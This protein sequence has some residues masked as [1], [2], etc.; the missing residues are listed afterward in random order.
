[1]EDLIQKII[2]GDYTITDEDFIKYPSLGRNI[3]VMEAA[4]DE[5]PNF[6]KYSKI[7]YSNELG[8]MDMVDYDL[9]YIDE[10]NTINI[11][12]Y[13]LKNG[14]IPKG[15]DFEKNKTLAK[16]KS[17]L[18]VAKSDLEK[19][20]NKIENGYTVNEEEVL[21]YS[22]I[23]ENLFPETYEK[24]FN[25]V[26]K[27][28]FRF[29]KYLNIDKFND[30]Q[31]IIN[32]R[33]IKNIIENGFIPTEDDFIKN[34]QL[35]FS[36]DIMEKAI[37]VNP[38][39]IKYIL[40]KDKESF[41]LK[42]GGRELYQKAIE[43][44]YIPLEEDLKNN[45]R[46]A[47]SKIILK[48][49]IL[50]NNKLFKYT[51]VSD[52]D[53]VN[54]ALENGYT[55]TADDINNNHKLL[56][57]NILMKKAIDIDCRYI[58]FSKEYFSSK[59]DSET[60]KYA[61]Q[62]G[63]IPTNDDIRDNSNW[64][65]NN[66][67]MKVLIDINPDFVELSNDYEELFDYAIN[68][69]YSPTFVQIRD[70]EILLKSSKLCNYL[71]KKDPLLYNNKFLNEYLKRDSVKGI[72]LRFI[73]QIWDFIY[74]NTV[75]ENMNYNEMMT[76]IKYVYCVEYEKNNSLKY[77]NLE[78]HLNELISSNHIKEFIQI[79]N[80]LLN[81][82]KSNIKIKLQLM[83][84]V[85][86]NFNRYYDLCCS[87]LSS[88][89]NSKDIYLLRYLLLSKDN[90]NISTIEELGK[91]N[92]MLFQQR[93]NEINTIKYYLESYYNQIILM[94]FNMTYDEYLIKVQNGFSC[95]NIEIL[96]KSIN[97]SAIKEELMQY[98]IVIKLIESILKVRDIHKLKTFAHRLNEAVYKNSEAIINI[99]DI[100][101]NIEEIKKYYY[102]IEIQEKLLDITRLEPSSSEVLNNEENRQDTPYIRENQKY[103][104]PNVDIFGKSLNGVKVD[105]IELNGIEFTLF[106]HVLNAFGSGGTLEDFKRSRLYGKTYICVSPITDDYYWGLAESDEDEDDDEAIENANNVKLVFSSMSPEQLAAMGNKDL[107]SDADNNSL[108]IT[109]D[110]KEHYAPI[111]RNVESLNQY[112]YSGYCE[113]VLYR[114]NNNGEAIYPSAILSADAEPTQSEIIAAAYLQIPIL[115]VNDIYLDLDETHKNG[116]ILNS[117]PR[118]KSHKSH[119]TIQKELQELKN[120]LTNGFENSNPSI[121]PE[122]SSK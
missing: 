92:E 2:D 99:Y 91:Y 85:I 118:Q 41:D 95:E 47:S 76:I 107:Y 7:G 5:N 24:F 49:A 37:D 3:E 96:I 12:D 27:Q 78:K 51:E 46:L 83:N 53:I 80:I 102:G 6:I 30:E 66:D 21:N 113:Y 50:I 116:D 101:R 19:F 89:H 23:I 26:L 108:N 59:I 77:S 72:S 40:F 57:S 68:K 8:M 54:F 117:Q 106:V 84:D 25:L 61:I 14:Y 39:F 44:G 98:R 56:N 38:Q 70:N 45:F 119:K 112:S 110:N 42:R 74:N 18:N 10:S 115:H 81:D 82:D 35:G 31:I 43:S 114:E 111:R 90:I 105:Y 11:Y 88:N 109:T 36:Y 32:E 97:N 64:K 62:K 73:K 65:H 29:I 16:H 13:A 17:I 60:L 71:L 4:I 20:L 63:Y 34:P 15:I 28:N 75:Y 93:K 86:E 58:L 9:D 100:V 122:R 67:I 1:M 33:I 79:I 22:L 103:T 69:G 52:D 120:I 48:K 55:L 94:I 104:C 87:F 121:I